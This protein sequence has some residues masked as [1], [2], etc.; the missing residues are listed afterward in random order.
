MR[1][2]TPLIAFTY[3]I[4]PSQLFLTEPAETSMG[5]MQYGLSTIMMI[6]VLYAGEKEIG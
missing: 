6:P 1:G 2:T 4:S 3:A 5:P